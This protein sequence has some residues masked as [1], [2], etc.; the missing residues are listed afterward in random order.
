MQPANTK[1][2]GRLQTGKISLTDFVGNLFSI[3]TLFYFFITLPISYAFMPSVGQLHQ[4]SEGW[5][6]TTRLY[7]LWHLVVF[8]LYSYG[9]V[10]FCIACWWAAQTVI[11][12]IM[13]GSEPD[14]IAWRR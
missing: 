10:A 13:F 4:S 3:V 6:A 14:Y 11:M 12:D 8:G 2:T 1:A 7:Q 9:I 5:V